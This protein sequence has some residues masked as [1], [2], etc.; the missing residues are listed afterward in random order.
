[1]ADAVDLIV[2]EK[3]QI[4]RDINT[5]RIPKRVPIRAALTLEF[6]IQYAG[7][8]LARTL[9]D[10]AKIEAVYDR[11][12]SDFPSDLF[13]VRAQRFPSFYQILGARTFVMSSSGF[14]QHPEVEG[15]SVDEY[16]AFIDSPFDC[17]VEKVLPRLYSELDAPPVQRALVFAKAMR[18]RQDEMENLA[19]LKAKMEAKYGYSKIPA[20]ESS[21]MTLT[22]YDFLADFLRGFKGISSD[23]RRRPEKVI[24]A[25]EAVTPLLIK[26]GTPPVPDPVNGET[27]IPLHMAPY[28]REKDFEKFYWPTFKKMVDALHEM[29]QGIE[30]FVEHDWT[31]YLDYLLELPANTV[32]R[33][34]Y[35]DPKVIK[36]KLGHKHVLTGFYPLIL[37]QT[38]TKEQC[39]D[40][41]RELLDIL[42]PGGRYIF[43]CDKNPLTMDE[44]GLVAEN[45]KAVL[46]FVRL[47]GDY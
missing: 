35:G 32:M 27:F 10:T 34:E 21:A 4:Y 22:P 8:D 44:D 11:V 3:T 45:Y 39:L 2:A 16:D 43:G 28:M 23:I 33:F 13:P 30:L 20:S 36:Q 46:E 5:G 40:K 29:G 14:I 26:K 41:A 25:C 47:H 37:L 19:R 17:I 6:A 15:L 31:R 12:C 7:Y 38:G 18:A 9:W 1:M 24:A 42:A